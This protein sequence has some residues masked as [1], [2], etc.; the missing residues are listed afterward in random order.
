MGEHPGQINTPIIIYKNYVRNNI[1]TLD[2]NFDIDKM[3]MIHRIISN[4]L[5]SKNRPHGKV[6]S[7]PNPGFQSCHGPER[8]ALVRSSLRVKSVNSNV[9]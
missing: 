6:M 1:I 5:N 9:S 4:F 7:I 8:T 2:Q 3:D